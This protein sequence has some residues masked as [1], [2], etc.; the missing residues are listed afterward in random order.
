MQKFQQS[1]Q[2]GLQYEAPINQL[3]V[4]L[5]I[6]KECLG[7]AYKKLKKYKQASQ[8]LEEAY[9]EM[10]TLQNSLIN[11]KTTY[12]NQIEYFLNKIKTK[13]AMSNYYQGK[14]QNVIEMFQDLIKHY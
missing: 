13:I 11:L 6:G 1:M 5:C 12:K 7:D 2:K 9:T 4:Q 3:K 14:M 10:R 8:S